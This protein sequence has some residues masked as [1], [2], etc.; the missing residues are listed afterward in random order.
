MHTR[1]NPGLASCAAVIMD[2]S[3]S[4]VAQAAKFLGVNIT[5][6]VAEYEGLILGM[7]LAKTKGHHKGAVLFCMDSELVLKQVEGSYKVK[8]VGLKKLWQQVLDDAKHFEHA[9]YKHVPRAEN[10]L[11]DALANQAIDEQLEKTAKKQE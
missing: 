8:A 3:G 2:S 6:N 7:D 9:E 4:V 5:N 11:S 10:Y 1:G